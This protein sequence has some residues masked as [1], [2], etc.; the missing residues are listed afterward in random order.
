M[1][2]KFKYQK[3]LDKY[4]NCPSDKCIER[5]F[6]C[7]RWVHKDLSEKDFEPVALMEYNP[8]R[9]L[10]ETDLRC[11]HYCLSVYKDLSSA[12]SN[13]NDTYKRR[14]KVKDKL[15]DNFKKNIGDHS[16]KLIILKEHGKSD[17]PNTKTGH[18]SF[19]PYEDCSL[20][21]N[22]RGL[23]DNFA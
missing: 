5:D 21:E 15:A 6:E 1:E 20:L 4:R 12:K 10:D 14:L 18:I 23:F 2:K 11:E 7:Y 3:Y 9:I 22:V 16:A 13:Y 17:E 8:P 19:H